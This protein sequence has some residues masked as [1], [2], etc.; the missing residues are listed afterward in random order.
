MDHN[1]GLRPFNIGMYM[2][3]S[4]RHKYIKMILLFEILNN[5]ICVVYVCQ[6]LILHLN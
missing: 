1:K 2:Y 6:N 5:K 4:K 3:V